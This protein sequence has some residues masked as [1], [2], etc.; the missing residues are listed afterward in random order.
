MKKNSIG[1]FSRRLNT[2][3]NR[4]NELKDTSTLNICIQ[5][6]RDKRNKNK[7]SIACE[8]YETL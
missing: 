4:I 2:E 3:E 8:L 1:K 5:T 7:A 6:L